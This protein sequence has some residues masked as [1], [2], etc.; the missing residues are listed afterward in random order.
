[1]CRL[2]HDRK[3]GLEPPDRA[4]LIGGEAGPVVLD[5][6]AQRRVDMAQGAGQ[7]GRIHQLDDFMEGRRSVRASRGQNLGRSAS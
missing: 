3:A 6:L 1:M 4:Q 2:G 7:P 5:A